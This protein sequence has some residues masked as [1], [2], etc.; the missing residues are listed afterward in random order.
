MKSAMQPSGEGSVPT[1]QL[2]E[3]AS[4]LTHPSSPVRSR[5]RQDQI[6]VLNFV[7]APWDKTCQLANLNDEDGDL[8]RV[9][10]DD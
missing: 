1:A 4:D 9:T 5:T 8:K 7:R 6:E 2:A 10:C 3:A